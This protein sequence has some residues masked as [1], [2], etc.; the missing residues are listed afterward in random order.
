M[1]SATQVGDVDGVPDSWL[2]VGP[3]LTVVDIEREDVCSF[4]N[5]TNKL[6]KTCQLFKPQYHFHHVITQ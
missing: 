4:L 3:A 6:L 2:R 1:A 5:E